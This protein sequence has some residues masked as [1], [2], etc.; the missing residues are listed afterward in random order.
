[1]TLLLKGLDELA[2]LFVD[3]GWLA[4]G[5]I[6]VVACAG[7]SATF[8]PDLP[9]VTGAVLL[10]G[11]LGVLV[12]NVALSVRAANRNEWRTAAPNL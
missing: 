5:I 2:G 7:L 1:M 12:A 11:C 8:L 10:F 6:A 9:L 4:L 3:D